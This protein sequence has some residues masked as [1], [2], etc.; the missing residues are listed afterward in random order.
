[1]L[2]RKIYNQLLTSIMPHWTNSIKNIQIHWDK[3]TFSTKKT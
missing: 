3:P 2:K 1:M